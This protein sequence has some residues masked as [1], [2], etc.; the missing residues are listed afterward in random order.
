MSKTQTSG[1]LMTP[2]LS[3]TDYGVNKIRDCSRRL[4]LRLTDGHTDHPKH[5]SLPILVPYTILSC[6]KPILSTLHC[7]AQPHTIRPDLIA[8]AI[9]QSVVFSVELNS[10]KNKP[11]NAATVLYNAFTFCFDVGFVIDRNVFC[12]DGSFF[13]SSSNHTTRIADPCNVKFL[14]LERKL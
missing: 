9:H 1:S 5:D 13:V 11:S 8:A 6:S 3:N 14:S 12:N 10:M 7:I 2:T 4:R